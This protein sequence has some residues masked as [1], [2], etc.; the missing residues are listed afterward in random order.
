MLIQRKHGLRP[1]RLWFR[2]EKFQ[3]P[4]HQEMAPLLDL[5]PANLRQP[6]QPGASSKVENEIF[7]GIA[8][9]GLFICRNRDVYLKPNGIAQPTTRSKKQL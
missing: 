2:D 5:R 4:K 8:G 1:W 6:S 3:D 9:A 7:A